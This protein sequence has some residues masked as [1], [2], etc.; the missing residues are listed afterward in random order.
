M[1]N[2]KKQMIVALI[3]AA[4][5]LIVSWLVRGTEYTQHV[6]IGFILLWF[7]TDLLFFHKKKSD[8]DLK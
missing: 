7:I 4:A 2:S 3:F 8:S 1:A 5:M 6:I